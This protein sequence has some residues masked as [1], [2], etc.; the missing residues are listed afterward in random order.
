[1]SPQSPTT[2]N[3]PPGHPVG[4]PLV[5]T[6]ADIARLAEAT[7]EDIASAAAEFER[8]ATPS[9]KR[10]LSRRTKGRR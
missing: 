3:K 7:P 4:E 5:L 2:T 1:M 9:V 10:L 8:L 6:A